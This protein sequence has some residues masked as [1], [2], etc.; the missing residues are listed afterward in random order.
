MPRAV[1]WLISSDRILIIIHLSPDGDAIASALALALTL[2]KIDKNIDIVCIDSIPKPFQFL[3]GYEKIKK[4]FFQG[5][6]DCTVVLDCGDL[7][8]TG[9]IQRVKEF[10]LRK[11]R[12]IN[13]DHHPKNDLHKIANINIHDSTVSST[14]EIVEK[15]IT[16]LNINIDK[17]IATC[18]LTGIYTDT[19]GF[20]HPNTTQETLKVAS[21]LLMKGARLKL[22]T[23]NISTYKSITSLK[24]W[25]KV[26]QK[27]KTHH[28]YDLAYSLVTQKDLI[29][30]DASIEDLGGA[31]N[32]IANIS[33]TKAAIL[34]MEMPDNVIR[35]SIRSEDPLT[36]VSKIAQIFDGGGHKKAAGFSVK[37]KILEKKG[38]W[39]II[40]E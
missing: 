29:S 26:L 33:G 2:E 22:I 7:K 35:A 18:L 13:I 16:S 3:P 36:D 5:D 23:K 40:L 8:R 30:F 20:R 1:K 10:A 32:L 38:G 39:G 27:I 28:K 11:Q 12:L 37:G 17:D 4:D 19:G 34:F 31:T 9:N 25:G 14:A 15:L 6:Y 21:N 24:L